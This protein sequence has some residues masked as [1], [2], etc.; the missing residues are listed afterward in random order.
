MA[1]LVDLLYHIAKLYYC[2]YISFAYLFFLV[3]YKAMQLSGTKY[4]LN[5]EIYYLEMF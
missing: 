4:V 2:N 3:R 1:Y 5:Y